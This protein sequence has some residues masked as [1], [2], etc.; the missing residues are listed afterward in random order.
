MPTTTTTYAL[1]KPTVGGDTDTWGTLLNA[2]MDSLDDL[3]DGTTAIAPNLTEGSWKVGGVAVLPTAAELNFVDGVTSAIQTQLNAKQAS[4]A[5]LTALAAYNTNGILTQTAADTFA[6]RTITAS[7]GITVTNG[8]GVAGNPTIAANVAS[9]AQAI[10]GTSDVVLLTP[11]QL[12]NGLNADGTAPVYACRAWV[13]WNGTGTVAIRGA[14][15]VTSITDNGVGLYTVNFTT[16]MSDTNYAVTGFAN[17]GGSASIAGIMSFGSAFA[18]ATGS[19]Q[20]NS[21]NSTTGVAQ[22]AQHVH[23]AVFR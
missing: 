9:S 2:N 5:T 16:A 11:L 17:F 18:P 23:I 10:A 7:T 13:N 14:G 22:D 15:N 4:D 19:V 20:V 12:R 8:S 3:L 6:G 1:S 21:G